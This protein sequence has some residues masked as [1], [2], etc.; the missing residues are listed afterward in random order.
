MSSMLS[1][2]RNYHSLHQVL[3]QTPTTPLK[4]WVLN[5]SERTTLVTK[6]YDVSILATCRTVNSEAK[7]IVTSRLE[8]L[9]A[10]PMRLFVNASNMLSPTGSF[11]I[12]Q[13]LR[14][15]VCNIY[16]GSGIG[17]EHHG[18]DGRTF[19]WKSTDGERMAT[20]DKAASYTALPSMVSSAGVLIRPL[21]VCI[22]VPASDLRT[23]CLNR[24]GTH[25]GLLADLCRMADTFV[26]YCLPM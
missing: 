8:Q 24:G 18:L 2:M 20:I 12:M 11:N 19:E 1:T 14:H 10:N 3:R 7:D 23:T 26:L 6:T 22:N 13:L 16:K 25:R 9:R 15:K 17:P 21:V 4:D 5:K